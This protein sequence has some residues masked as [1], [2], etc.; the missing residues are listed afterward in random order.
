MLNRYTL[1]LHHHR[2]YWQ[3]QPLLCLKKS[4]YRHHLRHQYR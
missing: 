3:N 4:P 1:R 2:Q